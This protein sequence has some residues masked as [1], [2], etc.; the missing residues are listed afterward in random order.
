MDGKPRE[1]SSAGGGDLVQHRLLS[2]TCLSGYSES[3]F[4]KSCSLGS[5]AIIFTTFQP[6]K[7]CYTILPFTELQLHTSAQQGAERSGKLSV[8]VSARKLVSAALLS[9]CLQQ[10]V[11]DGLKESICAAKFKISRVFNQYF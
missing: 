1:P 4:L 9:V 11:T 10:V 7:H 8:I 2:I 6:L 5:C 3:W